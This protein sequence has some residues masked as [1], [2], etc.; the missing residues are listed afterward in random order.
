MLYSKTF[1]QDNSI[2]FRRN[3]TKYCASAIQGNSG[4]FGAILSRPPIEE[5][6]ENVAQAIQL[7]GAGVVESDVRNECK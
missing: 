2:D 6:I 4:Q 3:N 7:V 5:I 1:V